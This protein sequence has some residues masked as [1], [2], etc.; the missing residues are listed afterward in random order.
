MAGHDEDKPG[1]SD[2]PGHA[3][4][5]KDTPPAN[6]GK[7]AKGDSGGKSGPADDLQYLMERLHALPQTP[8][9]FDHHMLSFANLKE[10]LD[11][12]HQAVMT[13]FNSNQQIRDVQATAAQSLRDK[14]D[15]AYAQ[16]VSNTVDTANL[17]SKIAV[18]SMQTNRAIVSDKFLENPN[19]EIRGFFQN[20]VFNQGIRGI[21]VAALA[22]MA[23]TLRDD[24]SDDDKSGK[25]GE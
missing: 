23:K 14:L 24:E 3:G 9:E 13:Q 4:D 21:V 11:N 19:E 17:V 22:E 15:N 7:P 12:M 18:N 25:Q 8:T 1:N 5:G 2:P 10:F 20:D 6:K 16:H